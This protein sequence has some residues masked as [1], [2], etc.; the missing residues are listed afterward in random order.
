MKFPHFFLLLKLFALLTYS[1]IQN[2]STGS[3][4][5]YNHHCSSTC[6]DLGFDS[7]EVLGYYC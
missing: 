3:S 2:L 5:V 7:K 6:C 4:C 1:R